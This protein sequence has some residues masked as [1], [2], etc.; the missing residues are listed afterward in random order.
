[1]SERDKLQDIKT[2][3]KQSKHSAGR[4]TDR[5][6]TVTERQRYCKTAT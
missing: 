5:Q 4:Q 6:K 1:M 2:D 3:R